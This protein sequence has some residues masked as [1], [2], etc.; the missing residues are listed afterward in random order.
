[1]RGQ[2]A[3][4]LAAAECR[5]S[6]SQCHIRHMFASRRKYSENET[7]G[8]SNKIKSSNLHLPIVIS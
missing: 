7:K 8:A 6:D 1:M 4:E 3:I 5:F 2:R